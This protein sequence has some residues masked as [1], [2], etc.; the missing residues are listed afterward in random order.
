MPDEWDVFATEFFYNKAGEVQVISRRQWFET[1][2][3]IASVSTQSIREFRGNGRTRY[4]MRDRIADEQ[5][6]N[7]LLPN[8]DSGTWT[9]YDGELPT[10]DTTLNWISHPPPP[11]IPH[12]ENGGSTRYHLGLA[13]FTPGATTGDFN[14]KYFHADHLGTTRAMTDEGQTGPPA[15]PPSA[16]PRLVYT[17]FGEKV[18]TIGTADTRYQYVGQHGYETFPDLPYQH[19]GHRWYDPSTGRFLQ[20]D[21]IG[22]NGGYNVF[23]YIANAPL[24][25]VDPSGLYIEHD[26][27][28]NPDGSYTHHY[29]DRGWFGWDHEYMGS[30][31]GTM[32]VLPNPRTFDQRFFAVCASTAIGGMAG[33]ATGAVSGAAAGS[34]A[35][36]VGAGPGAIVGGIFGTAVGGAGGFAKGVLTE[37]FVF[38][39]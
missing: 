29:Y 11:Q 37:I 20:R 35:G 13:Q 21:P 26:T 12:Y 24:D 38:G 7:Y 17:A 25:G 34:A 32:P 15:V 39:Y 36:G 14:V 2:A 1:P 31:K 19:V 5:A 27:Y 9:S 22:I 3:G 28:R 18:S 33:A 6:S 10:Q 8:Y 23:A 4:M 30:V 16:L